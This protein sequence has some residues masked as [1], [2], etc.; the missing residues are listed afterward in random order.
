M[1]RVPAGGSAV[2]GLQR[3]ERSGGDELAAAVVVRGGEVELFEPGD[4]GGLVA[5]D[6]GAH[7]G[8]L[9]GGGLGHRPAADADEAERVLFAQDSGGRGGGELADRVPGDAGDG[10]AVRRA[11]STRA[12]SPRR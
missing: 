9:G 5:A 10:G 2:E 11:R 7:A 12:G 1:T 6:D 4:D 3:V 8:L